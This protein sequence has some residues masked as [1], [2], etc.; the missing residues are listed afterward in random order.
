LVGVVVRV[1]EIAVVLAVV[2]LTVVDTATPVK[3]LK[4]TE[5]GLAEMTPL[6]VVPPHEP[7]QKV[8]WTT[9]SVPPPEEVG[10][11]VKEPLQVTPPFEQLVFAT[12]T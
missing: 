2:K 6:V 4:V 11:S 1:K 8:T 7:G 3:V 5:L 10:C 9:T 12:E